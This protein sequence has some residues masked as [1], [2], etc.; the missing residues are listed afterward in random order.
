MIRLAAN[1]SRSGK[2]GNRF[3]WERAS[4]NELTGLPRKKKRFQ[5]FMK[6][7][8]SGEYLQA[9]CCMQNC[10]HPWPKS[11]L[12]FLYCWIEAN[13]NCKFV[14]KYRGRTTQSVTVKMPAFNYLI[15]LLVFSEQWAGHSRVQT[16]TSLNVLGITWEGEKHKIQ[17]TS[18][19]EVGLQEAWKTY[20]RRK[21]LKAS[22]Q[23]MI[24]CIVHC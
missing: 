3:R 15:G 2:Q 10:G 8:H 14:L 22:L 1:F 24:F 6:V 9:L 23:D 17:S 4:I 11:L 13:L 21:T 16:S 5:I 7:D 18:N 20:P 19:P 12:Q